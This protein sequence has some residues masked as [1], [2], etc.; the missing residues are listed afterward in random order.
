MAAGSRADDP[1]VEGGSPG[2]VAAEIARAAARLFAARGYDATPV[3][4]IVEA[5]GVTKPTL[6]YHFG[7]KQGLAEALLTRPLTAF[8]ARLRGLRDGGPDPG[9]LL[10][11]SVEVHMDFLGEEPDRARF[12]YAICFGG[13]NQLRDEIRGFGLA[14]HRE[15]IASARYAAEA[16]LIDPGR[17]EGFAEICR[18]AIVDASLDL[19]F[20]VRAPDPGMPARLVRD[21]IRGFGPEPS[22]LTR[23]RG[24]RP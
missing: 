10:R 14:I 4:E 3:R 13:D 1:T 21:L 5:A 18:G 11:R 16:G 15:M 8:V 24:P 7:S 12:F 9:E 23:A 6:Y 20:G 19:L 17:A 2:E 22:D